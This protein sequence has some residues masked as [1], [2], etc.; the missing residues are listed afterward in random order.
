M[1]QLFCSAAGVTYWRKTLIPMKAHC[2][3]S[4]KNY[5][6]TDVWPWITLNID[7]VDTVG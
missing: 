1:E 6:K 3:Y 7:E 4:C 5:H 2:I